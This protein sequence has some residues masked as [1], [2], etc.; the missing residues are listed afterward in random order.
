M[1]KLFG[2]KNY[3]IDLSTNAP[4]I[5]TGSNGSGKSTILS[6]V[7]AVSAGDLITMARAPL[8]L[9]ELSFD[10]G[11][12]FLFKKNVSLGTCSIEWG[13]YSPHSFRGIVDEDELPD[14]AR[15]FSFDFSKIGQKTAAMELRDLARV[16]HVPLSEYRR[17]ANL[18]AFAT[19]GPE[20]ADVPAWLAHLQNEFPVALITDQRLLMEGGD[21]R[22]DV[23]SKNTNQSTLRAVENASRQIQSL[24]MAADSTYSDESKLRDRLFPR[25][26]INAITSGDSIPSRRMEKLEADVGARRNSLQRVGLLAYGEDAEPLVPEGS[27]ENEHV[28]PVIAT[29]LTSTLK[30]FSV[31]GSLATKLT[32]FK[33]FLDAQFADKDTVFSKADGIRF[34]LP[35][36]QLL[37]P[38][39]LSSGE[40]QMLM[41]AYEITFSAREGTLVIIDEPELSLHVSWQDTLVSN[42]DRMGKPNRLKFLMATHSPT[43]IAEHTRSE[44]SLD[45]IVARA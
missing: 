15:D 28:R 12:P 44:R 36:G 39:N 37:A 11:R 32:A 8:E 19:E 13:E 43:L 45:D 35:T 27:L 21:S 1:R 29:F 4:T 17:V 26:V 7:K 40:Q 6:L 20:G 23:L 10:K 22:R 42:L 2:T 38:T 9:F 41:L 31:L 25:L 34:E 24:M 18:V 14:W 5:L 16:N 3:D 30:K 33:D